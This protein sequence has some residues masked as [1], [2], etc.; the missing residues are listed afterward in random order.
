MLDHSKFSTQDNSY[1]R[2]RF[3]FLFVTVSI[4]VLLASSM[5]QARQVEET[6]GPKACAD[7]HTSSVRAWKASHHFKTFKSLP[8]KAE[9]K[10]IA[11]KMGIKRMK[12]GSDC[13]TCHFTEKPHKNKTKVIAGISCESCHSGGQNW[14]DIHSD[15]GGNGVKAAD[16]SAEHK[17]ERYANSENAGMI[18]PSNIYNVAKN[19][20]G[21]HTVPN[22][23]L[24]N[25]GGHKAG[26]AIE[27][28]Q[29][30]QGEVRH[31]VWYSED[32]NVSPV[33]RLRLM[34]VVGKALDLEYALRGIAKAT[35]EQTYFTEMVSR[36][37]AALASV[38]AVASAIGNAEY[39]SI[40]GV[41]KDADIKINNE[42]TLIQAADKISA[43]T[44]KIAKKYSGSEFS[45]VDSMLPA[46][47]SYKGSVFTP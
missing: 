37:K 10:A 25:V 35:E 46:A 1:L 4:F 12:N 11:K 33:E 2:I 38:K 29:W 44:K 34:F 5:A 24:V 32:N 47:G 14:I 26:S 30:S 40:A 9:A 3:L 6:L 31:N 43:I 18:R 20:Y 19:C 39:S 16:E 22:E 15:F 45:G 23:K 27:L 41:V 28:V 17:V 8:R 21:C 13:L 36:Q 7:C 42:P